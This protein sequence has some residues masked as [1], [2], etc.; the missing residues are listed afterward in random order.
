MDNIAQVEVGERAESE[1]ATAARE[2]KLFG[3]F[4]Y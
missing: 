1:S 4:G 2:G 3:L